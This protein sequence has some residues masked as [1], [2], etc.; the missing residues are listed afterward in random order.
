[1]KSSSKEAGQMSGG[2]RVNQELGADNQTRL[3]PEYYVQ[4]LDSSMLRTIKYL[5]ASA[6]LR[7]FL[8][9]E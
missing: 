4:A 7:T 9:N 2:A 5:T 1:M 3:E 8:L 6:H